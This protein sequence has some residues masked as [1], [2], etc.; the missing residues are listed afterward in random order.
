MLL[1]FSSDVV[2]K[3]EMF[4][5]LFLYPC[6]ANSLK[7]RSFTV[8]RPR[9]FTFMPKLFS[10]LCRLAI[11]LQRSARKVSNVYPRTYTTK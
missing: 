4:I 8:H 6:S 5:V 9:L 1:V 10:K 2:E 11:T 3:S 7:E